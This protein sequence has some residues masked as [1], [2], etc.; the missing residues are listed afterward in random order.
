MA[1]TSPDSIFY[2]AE[3]TSPKDM[4][5]NY[6]IEK[7]G[8][9][10]WVEFD[11]F[12]HQFEILGVNERQYL[13]DNIWGC[14]ENSPKIQSQLRRDQWFG[15]QDHPWP[16]FDGQKLSTKRIMNVYMPNRSHKIQKPRLEGDM[17][18]AH[19]QTSCA[20]EAG[21][22]FA[23]EFVQSENFIP[24]FSCR[25]VGGARIVKGKPTVIARALTTY[26]WVL[27]PSFSKA[28]MCGD[29]S[30]STRSI[31]LMESGGS[32]M[33]SSSDVFVPFDELAQ[34]LEASDP[35]ISAFMESGQFS[36]DDFLGFAGNGS[37]M[38][39]RIGENSIMYAGISSDSA[40]RVKDFYRTFNI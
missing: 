25:C 32:D 40:E 11:A 34:D 21:R 22:G 3:Q 33:L 37:H 4:K 14:I 30:G 8:S 17:L 20:T 12:L 23:N 16:H 26:D 9:A 10:W 1:T 6:D 2:I 29:A 15:E 5:V 27:Y 19:I 13:G 36:H 39:M 31:P 28:E 7:K 35:N 18:K 38:A 24:T